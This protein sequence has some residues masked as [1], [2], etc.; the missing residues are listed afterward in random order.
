MLHH[1]VSNGLS[2][3]LVLV[4]L[5]SKIKS[6]SSRGLKIQTYG[7]SLEPPFS[8][9]LFQNPEKGEIIW[10]IFQSSVF[11][12]I[13]VYHPAWSEGHNIIIKSNLIG[14]E[15]KMVHHGIDEIGAGCTK[16]SCL[17]QTCLSIEL[18]YRFNLLIRMIQ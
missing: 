12:T 10:D 14:S 11:P 1:L 15:L 5:Y 2:L 16:Y 17:S 8:E 18:L 9:R 13:S 6:F 7:L 3:C 4:L